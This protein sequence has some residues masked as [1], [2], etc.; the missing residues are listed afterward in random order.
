[1][2]AEHHVLHWLILNVD[3]KFF[4]ASFNF[5]VF[6]SDA[7]MITVDEF[8]LIKLKNFCL[9]RISHLCCRQTFQANTVQENLGTR[10]QGSLS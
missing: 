8:K 4:K 6:G 9:N 5:F 2:A 1:M 3:G 10:L 7:V